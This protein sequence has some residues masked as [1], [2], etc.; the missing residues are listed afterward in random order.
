MQFT[1]ILL[2]SLILPALSLSGFAAQNLASAQTPRDEDSPESF[3]GDAFADLAIGVYNE[4]TT[5]EMTTILE[6]GVVQVIYGAQTAGLTGTGDQYFFQGDSGVLGTLEADD[7]F[8]RALAICDFDGDGFD[9]LAVGVPGQTVNAQAGAGQ[10]HVFYGDS[11]MLSTGGQQLFDQITLLDSPETDDHFGRTLAAADFNADGRCDLAV[12]VP[13]EDWDYPDSGMVQVIY[14][15]ELGLAVTGNTRFGQGMDGIFGSQ[16]E[17]DRFGLVL[18]TG[19][20][21]GD[22]FADLAVGV[23]WEALGG[24][25]QVGASGMVHMIYGSASGLITAGNNIFHQGMPTIEGEIGQGELFGYSLAAGDYNNDGFDDLAIGVIG[26]T[27]DEHPDAGMVHIIWGSASGGSYDNDLVLDALELGLN[28]SDNAQWGY[29]LE[30]SDFN[31]DGFADLV[32]GIPYG[33]WNVVNAGTVMVVYGSIFWGYSYSIDTLH[34]GYDGMAD[35]W[36]LEDLFGMSLAAGN[37]NGDGFAD[38]VIGA[39]YEN[40][41]TP[42][43]ADVGLIHLVFG[44]KDGITTDNNRSLA[45]ALDEIQGTQELN[46]HFG[47]VLEAREFFIE[48]HYLPLVLK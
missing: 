30:S 42:P 24:E 18:E 40:L 31:A 2:I 15:G 39:P 33:D 20:F 47:M 1:K 19:D 41:G 22:G 21:N 23:P 35:A 12:G 46:D 38:L 29:S 37:Y 36:E 7:N 43:I 14:G 4:D 11:A 10:V 13:Y 3:D 34:Q 48:R 5:P 8:G 32:L 6:S 26:Q 16:E 28:A 27:V 9:D 17:N 44:S 25:P 45:Q